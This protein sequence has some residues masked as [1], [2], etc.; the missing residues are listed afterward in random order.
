MSASYFDT[1]IF[2]VSTLCKHVSDELSEK[3]GQYRLMFRACTI[4]VKK[5]FV[6][7]AVISSN[8]SKYQASLYKYPMSFPCV[9]NVSECF[10]KTN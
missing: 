5:C 8:K 1:K 4:K 9:Y 3:S 10:S 6:S 7:N 2:N